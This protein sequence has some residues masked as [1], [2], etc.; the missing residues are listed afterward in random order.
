MNI[1]PHT[2]EVTQ[3]LTEI[4]ANQKLQLER[5]AEAL[6]LQKQQFDMYKIQFERAEK[7]Q[8]RAE[9][10]QSKSSAMVEKG[11]KVVAICIPLLIA[12]LIY[13]TWLMLR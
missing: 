9:A 2:A 4:R 6:A 8:D 7:L 11:R 1:D 13:T 5:Q 10:L 3:I 12:L